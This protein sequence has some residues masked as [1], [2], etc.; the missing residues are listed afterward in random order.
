MCCCFLTALNPRTAAGDGVSLVQA[1]EAFE[2]VK[3]VDSRHL[4]LAGLGPPARACLP[5]GVDRLP[6]KARLQ[7]LQKYISSF[8]YNHTDRQYFNV[9]KVLLL[10]RTRMS[11]WLSDWGREV[12][13]TPSLDFPR[14][15]HLVWALPIVTLDDAA[16]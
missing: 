3:L 15:V 4:A 7:V 10:S 16:F 2:L 8:Q 14:V 12:H 13:Q 11:A 9:A 6:A 5:E 1:K